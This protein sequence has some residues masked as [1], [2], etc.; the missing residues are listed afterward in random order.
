MNQLWN[1]LKGWKTYIVAGVMIVIAGLHAQGYITADQLELL[2][3]VLLGLLGGALRHGI[4]T[5]S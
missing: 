3:L 4:A 1:T 5:E 2:E